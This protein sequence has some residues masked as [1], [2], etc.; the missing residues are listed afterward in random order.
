MVRILIFMAEFISC[1]RTRKT[2]VNALNVLV[3]GGKKIL[4]K[5]Y[6]YVVSNVTKNLYSKYPSIYTHA[7]T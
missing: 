2:G 7:V 5:I 4:L 1:T 3:C 6:F